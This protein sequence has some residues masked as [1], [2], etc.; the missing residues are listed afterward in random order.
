VGAA[1]VHAR[2]VSSGNLIASER[3]WG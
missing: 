1:D 3:G 2:S